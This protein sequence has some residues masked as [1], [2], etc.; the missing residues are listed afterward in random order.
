MPRATAID[1]NGNVGVVGTGV[2]GH[3]WGHDWE[4]A[5]AFRLLVDG[6]RAVVIIG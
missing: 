3:I 5:G 2:W 4:L 1:L 6:H